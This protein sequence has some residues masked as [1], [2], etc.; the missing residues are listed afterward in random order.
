MTAALV[1]WAAVLPAGAE[2]AA[3]APAL[4]RDM[5]LTI[6]AGDLPSA[7]SAFSQATG[8]QILVDPRLVVGRHTDGA[9]GS[10]RLDDA[11][12]RLLSGTGLDFAAEG[13]S[14]VVKPASTTPKIE[15]RT[16]KEP[17]PAER[18]TAAASIP[19]EIVV[20]GYRDSISR[21]L[22]EKR[23]ADNVVDSVSSEDIGKFPNQNVAEALERVPGVSITR[24]RGE[25][26]FVRIRGLDPSF[27]ITTLNDRSISVAEN[28]RDSG[29]NA[30]Q[31]RFDTLPTELVSAIDVIKSPTA[32]RDEGGIGGIVNIRTFRPFDLDH[33]TLA[34]SSSGSQATLADR[35]DS[36]VS[37]LASWVGDDHRLGFLLS[38]VDDQRSLRQD[39]VLGPTWTLYPEGIPGL[40]SKAPVIDASGIRPTLETERRQRKGFNAAAQWAP[41]EAWEVNIDLMVTDLQVRYDEK[42]YSA[43]WNISKAVPGSVVIAD[44]AVVSALAPAT[45]QIGREQSELEHKS[46]TLGVNPKY[47]MAEWTL[48]LDSVYSRTDSDTPQPIR[49]SRLDGPIGLVAFSLPGT[50]DSVPSLTYLN[51]NLDDV[52]VVPG[53]RLEWRTEKASDEDEALQFDAEH[54]LDLAAFKTVRM[55]VKLRDRGHNYDRRDILVTDSVAGRDFSA[56]YFDSFPV[57]D[58]LAGAGGNLPRRWLVPD[59]SAFYTLMDPALLAT[60]LTSSD[61]R[62]SYTVNERIGAAYLM[63]RIEGRL[64]DR[65]LRGDVGLRFA[66]TR[67]TSSGYADDGTG[68]ATPI[69]VTKTYGNWLPSVNLAS[70]VTSDLVFRVAAARV[71]T[72]PNLTQLGPQLTLNSSGTILTAVGGN[73]NLRP[74]Q[75]WQ[76]DASLEWYFGKGSAL[77]AGVFYKDIDSFVFNQVSTIDDGGLS[78]QLTAPVNGG[79]ASV[80]GA[81][82]A[83]QQMLSFLPEPFD[84][85]GLQANYTITGTE[86]TYYDIASNRRFTDS[87]ADVARHSATLIGFFEKGPIGLRASYSWRGDVLSQVGTNGLSQYNDRA[88]GSLDLNLTYA[89]GQHL[90]LVLEGSNVTGAV[91]T[92]FV[93]GPSGTGRFFAGYTDYGRTAL[94]GLR[95][96]Y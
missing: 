7:L 8:L 58:F 21:S 49:R 29:Q 88:F 95:I 39:R 47:R 64:F 14:V 91:Q 45:S 15:G 76:Y 46:W 96:K 52:G 66:S 37:G 2:P 60:P 81:E 67:Q 89:V 10:F 12:T 50:A 86:A 44:G 69:S 73:P 1:A 43:D 63:S 80:F 83:Y 23:D 84:G 34:L 57:S 26:L 93:T 35:L 51:A 33:N 28:V 74:Y 82:F 25:G 9:N 71:I 85:L 11:L 53:R 90:S 24:D 77:S 38:A 27:A 87:L 79:R 62:N 68:G 3:A 20:N 36:H 59:T 54:S 56:G 75:A 61:H 41:D 65:P 22:A 13:D 40:T 70:D 48:S 6:G 31:F 78:Y 16:G 30:R 72:R 4:L 18:T 19:Q 92:Q 42:S 32:D 5:P 94:A 17:A 55:G